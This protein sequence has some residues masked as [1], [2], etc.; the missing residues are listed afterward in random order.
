MEDRGAWVGYSPRG[1]KGR[2]Q[3][4]HWITTDFSAS[5]L[6]LNPLLF[7]PAASSRSL[8][9][10]SRKELAFFQSNSITFH[11]Q[12]SAPYWDGLIHNQ[13]IIGCGD[14]IQCQTEGSDSA[15]TT[16]SKRRTDFLEGK[17]LCILRSHIRSCRKDTLPGPEKSRGVYQG[18]HCPTE[19]AEW[20]T[21]SISCKE[22]KTTVGVSRELGHKQGSRWTLVSKCCKCFS[23]LSSESVLQTFHYSPEPFLQV[24]SREWSNQELFYV[25]QEV[26][27]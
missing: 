7:P 17:K 20:T 15:E 9:K 5:L 14:V 2:V 18:R 25:N 4:K 21:Y 3:L 26:T 12:I 24:K 16:Y 23:N 13:V 8:R 19:W 6:T 27:T 11:S 22:S 1:H 10:R